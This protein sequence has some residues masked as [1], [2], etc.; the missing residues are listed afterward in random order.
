MQPSSKHKR[1]SPSKKNKKLPSKM[2][3]QPIFCFKSRPSGRGN[4]AL[5]DLPSITIL[6]L[7]LVFVA[8]IIVRG[9]KRRLE[10]GKTTEKESLNHV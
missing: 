10:A 6:C 1:V 5:F 2:F 7:C 9:L 4:L 3:R 8:W